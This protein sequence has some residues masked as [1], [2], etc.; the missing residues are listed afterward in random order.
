MN[1]AN[2]EERLLELPALIADAEDRY[3][4]DKRAAEWGETKIMLATVTTGKD[5]DTRKMEREA[6]VLGN[7]AQHTAQLAANGSE[8]AYHALVREYDAITTILRR[9][10]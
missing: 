5:A 8:A 4:L 1:A 6:A 7:D 3:K 9:G 10:A 2:L